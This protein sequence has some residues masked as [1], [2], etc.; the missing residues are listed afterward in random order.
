MDSLNKKDA[1]VKTSGE[2]LL[3][4]TLG[5]FVLDRLW[6]FIYSH[7]VFAS[8]VLTY[9]VFITLLV[10][11]LR[12]GLQYM[13]GKWTKLS[14]WWTPY[15]I[16]TIMGYLFRFTLQNFTYWLCFLI[17]LLIVARCSLLKALPLKILFWSGIVA[18]VGVFVQLF[19]PA[20]Y[21]A[22][23]S[24]LFLQ[25]DI[26]SL[27]TE[28]RGLNGFTYQLGA[29]ANMIVT[30]EIVLVCMK[31]KVAPFVLNRKWLY[32]LL[33]VLF[34]I[35][36]FL[37]GKRT[38]SA[39]SV[40]LPVFIFLMQRKNASSKVF[41]LFV[42][43]VVAI[44][45]VRFFI[46]NVFELEE[47]RFLSRF[48]SSYVDVQAG[49]DISSGRSGLA[50]L[51]MQAYYKK[52]LFGI[53]VGNFIRVTG[54]GTDVH[55]TYL[56]VLC[57]QGIVGFILY[58]LPLLFSVLY[59]RKLYRRFSGDVHDYV[60]LSFALQIMFIF[61]ALTSNANLGISIVV[62]FMAIAI[63]IN[64]GTQYKTNNSY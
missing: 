64:V 48:A 36:V 50:E 32:F 41:F 29:T 34:V 59:T 12:V 61:D 37:T 22:N 14:A 13:F 63:A 5:F 56:Q 55:N 47:T 51:A 58:V 9:V 23:I 6:G 26:I 46:G 35:G 40:V 16:Y 21:I 43:I 1:S 10:L 25:E 53:G 39:I 44:F 2:K 52:P 20:F 11:F 38:L 57:E 15:L 33:L 62:Y 42:V 19:F 60:L 7:T 45:G 31:E 27:W 3:G 49:T 17:L 28:D 24:P 8:N 30:A 18:M 4:F 54:A